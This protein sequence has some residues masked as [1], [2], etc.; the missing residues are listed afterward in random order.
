MTDTAT[1]TIRTA[2][3]KAIA[4]R[5]SIFG[6]WEEAHE[7]WMSAISADDWDKA[8]YFEAL[9]EGLWADYKFYKGEVQGLY[10]ALDALN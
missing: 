5:D 4:H 1:A 9:A 7:S 10:I 3:A 8:S 2:I 6:E